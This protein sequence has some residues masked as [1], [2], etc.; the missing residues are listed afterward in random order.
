MEGRK[1]LSAI[2]AVLARHLQDRTFI[3]GP[4][5]NLADLV[6]LAY[7]PY[8]E[9]AG[10]GDLIGAQPTLAGWWD[11]VRDRPSLATALE[12]L[13]AGAEPLRR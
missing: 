1:E 4:R 7:F 13:G 2:F 12:Q 8:L 10:A 9:E 6:W 3:G 5:F 11:R